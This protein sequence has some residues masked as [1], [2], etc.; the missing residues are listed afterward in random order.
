VTANARPR[1]VRDVAR[2]KSSR[3]QSQSRALSA[4]TRCTNNQANDRPDL[5]SR[6]IAVVQPF[7]LSILGLGARK[8]SKG[9]SV[10]AK[11]LGQ[12]AEAVPQKC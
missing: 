5:Y 3:D 2:R 6:A 10:F 4:K 1:W 8:P 9:A 12:I 11:K 7:S